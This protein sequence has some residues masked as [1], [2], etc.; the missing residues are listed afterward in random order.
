MIEEHGIVVELKSGG[1]ALVKAER[2]AGCESCMTKDICNPTGEGDK[3]IIEADNPV[4]ATVGSEV[5]FTV[6][7]GTVIKAGVFFYLFP[8]LG[9]IA[10]VVI[11][12]VASP[13]VAGTINKDL[14]SAVLGFV[15]MVAVFLLLRLYGKKAEESKEYRPTIVK[16]VK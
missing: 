8:L 13:G 11:G 6:S 16:V 7:A 14:F 5:M 3:M 15:L 9:F 12:Q 10:G 4:G 1:S 2:G